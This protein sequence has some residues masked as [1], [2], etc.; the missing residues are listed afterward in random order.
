MPYVKMCFLLLVA[1]VFVLV[2]SRPHWSILGN[3]VSLA[4]FEFFSNYLQYSGE[5]VCQDYIY[6]LSKIQAVLLYCFFFFLLLNLC[7]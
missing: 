4:Y 2:P 6:S 7:F 5:T 1:N 3:F